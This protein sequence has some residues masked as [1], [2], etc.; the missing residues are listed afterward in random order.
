M[1]TI[2]LM[3]LLIAV[4]SFISGFISH[5]VIVKSDLEEPELLLNWD[6]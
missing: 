4:L 1:K 3:I 5:A 2:I 6:R